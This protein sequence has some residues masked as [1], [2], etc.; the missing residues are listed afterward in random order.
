[1]IKCAFL[2]TTKLLLTPSV[3]LTSDRNQNSSQPRTPPSVVPPSDSGP[4]PSQPIPAASGSAPTAGTG[5][6]CPP[7]PDSPMDC[8]N[9]SNT[10]EDEA[11]FQE[12][13]ASVIGDA[14]ED[15]RAGQ[16]FLNPQDKGVSTPSKEQ[17]TYANERNNP[18]SLSNVREKGKQD[19]KR[20]NVESGKEGRKKVVEK[21]RGAVENV[22]GNTSSEV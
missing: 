13:L 21:R 12:N 15:I 14:E 10:D 20:S 18:K 22:N 5:I 3:V 9:G 19:R 11:K 8:S 2:L 16:E 17:A 1:M 7:L 4:Q 6:P